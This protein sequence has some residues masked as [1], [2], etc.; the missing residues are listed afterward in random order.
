MRKEQR[1]EA[2]LDDFNLMT[3]YLSKQFYQG[4]SDVFYSQDVEGNIVKLQI[5]YKEVTSMDYSKYIVTNCEHIEFGKPYTILEEHGQTTPLQIG[6][7]VKKDKFDAMFAYDGDDLGVHVKDGQTHFALWAPT[8]IEVLAKITTPAKQFTLPLE[9]QAQGVFKGVVLENLH[10]ASY[11]YLID[12]NGEWVETIDPYAF[13]SV[14][15]GIKSVVIDQAQTRVEL[16]HDKLSPFASPTQAIIY[17]TSVRDFTSDANTNHQHKRT[18]KGFVERGTTTPQ[19]TK[20]GFDYLIDLG[21]THVQLMPIYDFAT[22]DES[23]IDVFYNWGY[24]PHQFNVPEGSY[25]SDVNDPL[26]RILDLKTLVATCHQH[27]IRVVMDVVYNHVYEMGQ[28]AFEKTVPYYYF[29]RS[30]SGAVSNGS[31]CENDIDSARY[32]V[33]KFIVESTKMWVQEYGMDGFRFDLMGILDVDTLNIIDTELRKIKPDILLYGEGWNMPTILDD[34]HKGMIA[35]QH[36][37]PNIGHFNDFYRDH[38]KGR[39]AEHEISVKGYCTGDVN[40]KDAM[41][42]SLVGNA[43]PAPYVQLFDSPAKSINYVECHDNR[44]SWDKI[45][46]C[47]KEDRSDVRIKK[48]KLMIGALMVSM[49]VPF[50]HSGQEFCRTK[51]GNSNSY[52]SGD[53]INRLD[54]ER[55]DRYKEVVN[56]TKDMIAL[57]KAYPVFQFSETSQIKKHVYFK[58]LDKDIL[59]YGF[60]D[61]SKYIEFDELLIFFNPTY[62]VAYYCLD[63][64][65]TLLANEAG[66]I[67]KIQT[68]CVTINPHTMVVVGIKI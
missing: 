10:L 27:D 22:V 53:L 18:F 14:V 57:R 11:T 37:M 68:Q 47:C 28:S 46:E 20:T 9:R 12:I 48:H 24:D 6:L 52:M 23:N 2:Y 49:G 8:A 40:Y 67:E 25:A 55:K 64:Y 1:F 59:L 63:G 44:T 45:K 17:E 16:H 34:E 50:L 60:K 30:E 35:N 41:K 4:N 36:K 65:G 54:W 43:L 39:T 13:G 62:D 66:L 32:M 29:R 33:R 21:I 15:N 5:K 38:V 7:I 42:M 19:K 61:V 26:S 58:D 56:Y 3:I 51:N 31:F